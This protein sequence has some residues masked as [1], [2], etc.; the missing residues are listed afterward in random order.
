MGGDLCSSHYQKQ[1]QL[2]RQ[3]IGY[4]QY[5]IR[6][7]SLYW[8]PLLFGYTFSSTAFILNQFNAKHKNSA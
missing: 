7:F 8:P 1:I 6:V 5:F 3:M 4:I 2:F